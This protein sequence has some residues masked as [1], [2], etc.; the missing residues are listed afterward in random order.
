MQVKTTVKYLLTLIKMAI[1]KMSTNTKYQRGCG[2]KRTL[3]QIGGNENQYSH[4]EDQYGSSLKKLKIKCHIIQ[5][6][7]SRKDKN[8]NSKINVHPNVHCS[9]IYNSQDMGFPASSAGKESVCNA[10]DPSSIP[11]LERFLGVAVFQY[12][13]ASLM[14]QTVKNLSAMWETWVD[15]WIGKIPLRRAQQPTP[16]F[17]PEKSPWTAEAGGLQSMG[18]KRVRHN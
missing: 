3:L 18:S 11:G 14:V 2:E 7:Q 4:Y 10:G 13:W 9:T 12:S 8:F 15:P 6:S 17:L 1:I 5:Q 16:V